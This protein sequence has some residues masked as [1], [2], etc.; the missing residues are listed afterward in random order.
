MESLLSLGED[1]MA[2]VEV[3]MPLEVAHHFVTVG[4]LLLQRFPQV[5]SLHMKSQVAATVG[6]VVTLVTSVVENLLVHGV[7]VFVE[8]LL[9]LELFTTN[10]TL[11]TLPG[12]LVFRAVAL[13]VLEMSPEVLGSL[14]TVRAG[15]DVL[16]RVDPPDVSVQR[17]LAGRRVAENISSIICSD[18][19]TGTTV[20]TGK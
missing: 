1:L 13:S 11:E 12:P 4:T 5:N 6:L 3:E 8:K 7:D 20:H 2:V 9:P 16:L 10:P 15:A 17:T 19:T 14:P 18:L